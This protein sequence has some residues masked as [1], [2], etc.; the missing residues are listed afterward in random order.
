MRQFNSFNISGQDS[1]TTRNTREH[2]KDFIGKYAF[3]GS[4]FL[5]TVV[6]N[7]SKAL[8]DYNLGKLSKLY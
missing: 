4:N 8:L 5:E 1:F 3:I 7:R 2:K 6:E